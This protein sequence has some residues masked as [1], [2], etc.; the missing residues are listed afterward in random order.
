MNTLRT[1][2]RRLILLLAIVA[3]AALSGPGGFFDGHIGIDAAQ[4]APATKATLKS[5]VYGMF[6]GH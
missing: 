4:A 2:T 6:D 5:P 3:A 1:R